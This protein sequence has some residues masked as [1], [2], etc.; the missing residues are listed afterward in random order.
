MEITKIFD[1]IQYQLERFPR[2]DAFAMKRYGR[3]EKTSTLQFV[4]QANKISRGLLKM[5][6]KTRR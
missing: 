1:F 4:N 6:I 2:E 5:G 3:W